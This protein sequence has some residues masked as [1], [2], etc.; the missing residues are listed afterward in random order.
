[1][2]ATCTDGAQGHLTVSLTQGDAFGEGKGTA[3]CTGNAERYPITV[4][5]Q[6]P[7]R[8]EP[9]SGEA[10]AEAI[11]KDR[12]EVLDDHVWSRVLS[13]VTMTGR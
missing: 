11:V 10:H 4:P 2:L 5:A 9:G 8:F 13:L 6:G 7:V 3:Q 12:G 1:V